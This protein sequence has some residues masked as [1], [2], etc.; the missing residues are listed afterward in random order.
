MSDATDSNERS[1]EKPPRASDAE[2]YGLTEEDLHEGAIDFDFAIRPT[3]SGSGVRTHKMT[4][5]LSGGSIVS[6]AELLR[7]QQQ[8]RVSDGEVILGSL[9]EIQI[10]SVSDS[11]IA[12]K[13]DTGSK[14]KAPLP[15]PAAPK[16]KPLPAVTPPV[17]SVPKKDSLAARLFTHERPRHDDW[18]IETP[19][20]DPNNPSSSV[21]LA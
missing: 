10:D 8:Q 3:P 2:H 18:I 1:P 15:P 21:D 5:P 9:P 6:W 13:L 20:S 4:D 11:D 16:P 7:Q 14:A 12:G 17:P 19:V